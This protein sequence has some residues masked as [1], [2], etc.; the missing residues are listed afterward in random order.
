MKT[1]AS[2]I[3]R[4]YAKA[5][6]EIADEK[7]LLEEWQS[8][9]QKLAMVAEDPKIKDLLMNPKANR[10]Q[11]LELFLSFVEAGSAE[12]VNFVKVLSENKRLFL[13]PD[14]SRLYEGYRMEANNVVQA[15]IVTARPIDREQA[16]KIGQAIG[17]RLRRQ[18]LLR[19]SLD[20]SLLGGALVRIGDTVIDNSLQG[21]LQK[22]TATLS[23]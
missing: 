1:Q 14:I 12:L 7:K 21:R 22:L 2:I 6:F 10:A 20:P 16:Q 11:I 18:V 5:L 4:S 15:E 23:R 8:V 13:L 3:A 9:L 17:N 19:V